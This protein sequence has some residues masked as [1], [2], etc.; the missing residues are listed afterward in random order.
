MV[1]RTPGRFKTYTGRVWYVV[2][3]VGSRLILDAYGT[4]YSVI[5]CSSGR[6]WWAILR[7]LLI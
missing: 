6:V 3:L 5:N 7:R 1:R 4:S 2:L